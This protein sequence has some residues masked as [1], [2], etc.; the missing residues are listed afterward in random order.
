MSA[1]GKKKRGVAG[2][3]NGKTIPFRYG[4][5]NAQLSPGVPRPQPVAGSAFDKPRK[6]LTYAEATARD[7]VTNRN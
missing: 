6:G 5:H 3:S 2:A 1:E 4:M 7:T